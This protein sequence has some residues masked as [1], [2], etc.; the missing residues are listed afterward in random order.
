MEVAMTKTRKAS[1]PFATFDAAQYLNSDED[2]A[3]FLTAAANGGDTA[4]F[5]RALGTVARAR[6]MSALARDSGMS[7]VGLHKALSG[8]GKPSLDTVMRTLNSLGVH[9]NV[10]V[11]DEKRAKATASGRTIKRFATSGQATKRVAARGR[12]G[13]MV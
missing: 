10:V 1:G 13:K 6:N 11:N 12:A 7:R 2:I 5:V 3:A 4:H 8:D 9:L